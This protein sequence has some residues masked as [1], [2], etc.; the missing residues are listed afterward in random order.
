MKK[1][2]L[3]TGGGTAGHV[4]VNLAL[5]PKFLED[6]WKVI[7]V[8]SKDGIEKQLVSELKDVEYYSVSTRKT[9]PVL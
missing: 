1:T 8:G 4:M 5:I 6:G 7:Y 2:I 3:F 9:A